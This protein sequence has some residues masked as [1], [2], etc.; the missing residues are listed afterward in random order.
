MGIKISYR[1]YPFLSPLS[2]LQTRSNANKDR[3]THLTKTTSHN[4]PVWTL[5]PR[6]FALFAPSFVIA[7]GFFYYYET[8]QRAWLDLEKD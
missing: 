4:P 2:L 3:A 8:Y 1:C 6:V 5:D 7:E